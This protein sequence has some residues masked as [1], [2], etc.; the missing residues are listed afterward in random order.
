MSIWSRVTQVL[1]TKQQPAPIVGGQPLHAQFD[2]IGGKI[3]PVEVSRILQAANAGRPAQ[4][5]DL[6]NESRQKDCH[7]QS[8]C[9][10][11]EQAVGVLR[12]GFAPPANPTKEELEGTLLCERALLDWRGWQQL[13]EHMTASY[14][15]GFAAAE[16]RWAKVGQY[17]LPV[18]HIPIPPRDMIFGRDDGKLKLKQSPYDQE[19][20]D[21]LETYG[22]RVLQIQRRIV[23]DVPARE[24]LVRVLTWAA[25][26]RNWT[27]RD[28]IALG[29]VGWKPWR[30][31]TYKKGA[32]KDDIDN[33]VSILDRLGYTGIG[34][35]PES[36]EID[37]Q[38]PK[39]TPAGAGWVSVHRELFD[40]MG[41]E[42]SKAVLGNTTSIES[43]DHGS[44]ADTESRDQ[45]RISTKESDAIA[46]AQ[47]IRYQVLMPLV[48]MNLSPQCRAPIFWFVTDSVQDLLSF[49][50]AVKYFGDAGVEIGHRW[51]RSR[52]GVDDPKPGEPVT[53]H[54]Q[55]NTKPTGD[56][57]PT[58]TPSPDE[59]K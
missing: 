20:I 23:G 59:N 49:S 55:D 31:G 28:W 8:T 57:P 17:I 22:P 34:V 46:I 12:L 13:I 35:K 32:S 52:A 15:A 45:L 2:R 10:T 53:G 14:Y 29:E 50:R 43:S 36:T 47:E 21:L 25:L 5:L 27:M 38:W 33:L 11:R 7:L 19:G 4:L 44:R 37:V 54:V 48:Q 40:V 18:G 51:V 24:G 58:G 16:V 6:G 30:I 9:A 26:F 42:I 39:G 41:R 3:T 1:G 56:P